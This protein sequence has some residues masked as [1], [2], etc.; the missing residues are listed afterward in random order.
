MRSGLPIFWAPRADG[1]NNAGH[2]SG[3]ASNLADTLTP[4]LPSRPSLQF[5]VNALDTH[6]GT[7]V[8]RL[9]AWNVE[10]DGKERVFATKKPLW[11][12]AALAA[13]FD[14][15][16]TFD[17]TEVALADG[18]L[19]SPPGAVFGFSPIDVTV[20][21]KGTVTTYGPGAGA[22][23]VHRFD[24]LVSQDSYANAMSLM[25]GKMLARL[26]LTAP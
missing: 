5:F 4:L 7:G 12:G 24:R 11:A 13:I 25:T 17:G 9:V 23:T 14:N 15:T 20:S 1:P 18:L 22:H 26:M 2:S 19:Q 16:V 10:P 6:V 21:D 8:G 3:W